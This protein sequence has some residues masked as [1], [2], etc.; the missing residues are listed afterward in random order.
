MYHSVKEC[1]K[2]LRCGIGL[3]YELIRQG[4]LPAARIGERKLLVSD[5][6]IAEYVTAQSERRQP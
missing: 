6:A 5:V 1:A 3:V 4:K 2:E